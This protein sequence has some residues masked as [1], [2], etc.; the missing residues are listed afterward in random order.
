MQTFD[1]LTF[2]FP[3]KI[4]KKLYSVFNNRESYFQIF[5]VNDS[6]FICLDF[7]KP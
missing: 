5:N 7:L 1:N 3:V 4:T 2:Q 6:S